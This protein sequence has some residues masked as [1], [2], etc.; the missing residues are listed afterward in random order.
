MPAPLPLL[1]LTNPHRETPT[2]NPTLDHVANISSLTPISYDLQIRSP[3]L[4]T[5]PHPQCCPSSTPLPTDALPSL[6]P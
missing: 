2:L 4:H 6:Q 5:H 1:T 3:A